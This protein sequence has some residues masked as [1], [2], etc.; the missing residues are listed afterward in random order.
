MLFKAE[1]RS[2]NSFFVQKGVQPII[3]S[4]KF[5]DFLKAQDVKIPT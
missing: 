5:T 2:F 4:A 1:I 3:M